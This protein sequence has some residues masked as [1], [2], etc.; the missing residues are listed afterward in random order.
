M[1][2]SL[3]ERML[4]TGST[5]ISAVMSE[6][7]FFQDPEYIQTQHPMLN[8]AFSGKVDGGL[9]PGLTVFAGNSK[10]FKSA[11]ALYCLKAYMD[12]YSDAIGVLYDTEFGITEEYIKSFGL[13]PTRIIHIPIEHIEQLK[14]DFVKKLDS[15]GTDDRIMFI[16]DSI[17]QISSKK[18]V[19]DTTDEKSTTD[20]TRAKAIRSLLRLV[21]IRLRLKDIPCIM[22]NHVYESIGGM[23]PTTIIPGGTAMTY[24]PSTILIVT[25]SQEKEGTEL[26]GW[27]FNINV[28]KSRFVKEKAKLTF[29][30]MYETGIN[31][32]SGLLD[33]A[34]ES[35]DLVKPSNGW[36]QLVDDRTGEV[37]GPKMRGADTQSDTVLGKIVKREKFK[38]FI[39]DK[40][41]LTG[42]LMKEEEEDANL[43]LDTETD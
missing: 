11:L 26:S 21:T 23:Y 32:W 37:L 2:N 10:T 5:S 1:A 25:K 42:S 6:S 17:G 16:V 35:G 29:Q 31:R 13:D 18:E 38:Q 40:Y 19:E 27:N 30:V 28:H 41:R 33:L 12:K 14:F 4:K 36:Y 9:V 34:V 3:L 20:M 7:R 39:I 24:A 15:L 22:I 8:I 43:D